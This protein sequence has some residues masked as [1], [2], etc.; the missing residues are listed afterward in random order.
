MS[1]LKY[2]PNQVFMHFFFLM[3]M[4]YQE[5]LYCKGLLIEVKFSPINLPPMIPP[6]SAIRPRGISSSLS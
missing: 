3:N 1:V 4:T 2:N 6:T 5:D